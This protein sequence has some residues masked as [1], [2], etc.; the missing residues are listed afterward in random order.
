M[1][2]SSSSFSA[3][4]RNMTGNRGQTTTQATNF[5]PLTQVE[6][7]KLLR[8]GMESSRQVRKAPTVKDLVHGIGEIIKRK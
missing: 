5:R 2:P 8:D 4:Q 3:I 7:T 6:F 1:N